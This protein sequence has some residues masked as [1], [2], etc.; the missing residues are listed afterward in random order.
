MPHGRHFAA[1]MQTEWKQWQGP[2]VPVELLAGKTFPGGKI[3]VA[4]TAIDDMWLL[5]IRRRS[6]ADRLTARERD[7]ARRFG[8][9]LD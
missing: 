1:M 3:V 9:G 6:P 5:T 8:R 7:I 4:A 2:C